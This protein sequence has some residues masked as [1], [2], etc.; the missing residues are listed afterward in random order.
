MAGFATLITYQ[1]KA[2]APAMAPGSWPEGVRL[3][4][5]SKAYNL[6]MFAHPECP[7]TDASLEELK[8][9]LAQGRGA[10]RPTICFFCPDGVSA[11]WT[12]TSLVRAARSVPGLN[13]V[14]DQNG[15][16]A[17]KFGAFTSGQVLMFDSRGHRVF[18]G[19]IT[20]SRGHSVQEQGAGPCAG[21][22][23]G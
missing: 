9:V 8:I 17:E 18:A 6:V 10:I 12:Q 11:D 13:V 20:G 14:I 23:K 15:A 22:G 19:G 21:V 4:L 2:G 16:I 3:T 5:D 7:C 1:M